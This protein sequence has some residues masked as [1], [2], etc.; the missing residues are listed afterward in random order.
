MKVIA[1]LGIV[2]GITVFVIGISIKTALT[3]A[4]I[5]MDF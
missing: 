4:S 5:Y 1:G 2:L 3:N